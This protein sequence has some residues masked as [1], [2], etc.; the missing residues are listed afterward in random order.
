MEFVPSLPNATV[1]SIVTLAPAPMVPNRQN[2][3]PL[4]TEHEPC[5]TCWVVKVALAGSAQLRRT[6]AASAGPALVTA[7]LCTTGNPTQTEDGTLVASSIKFASDGL[8][9]AGR[10]TVAATRE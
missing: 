5:E 10:L 8:P 6:L 4:F 2:T 3:R 1:N 7:K 9:A